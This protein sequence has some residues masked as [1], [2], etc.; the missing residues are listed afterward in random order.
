MLFILYTEIRSGPIVRSTELI[1]LHVASIKA[2]AR[3]SAS[4]HVIDVDPKRKQFLPETKLC[5]VVSFSSA[6]SET[7]FH[8]FSK[9]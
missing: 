7:I 8:C 3:R 9:K 2:I 5:S 4:P 1:P 6:T